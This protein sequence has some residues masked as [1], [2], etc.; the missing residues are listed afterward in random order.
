VISRLLPFAWV[1]QVHDAVFGGDPDDSAPWPAS[2]GAAPTG[3]N[4]LPA[5]VGTPTLTEVITETLALLEVPN[6]LAIGDALEREL[7]NHFDFQ[8]K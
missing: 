3:A 7:V 6:R 8:P 2:V 5:P 4:P 1:S